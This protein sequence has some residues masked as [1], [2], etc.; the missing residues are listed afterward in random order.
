MVT[1]PLCTGAVVNSFV[2]NCKGLVETPM[3]GVFAVLLIVRR[4]SVVD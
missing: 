4:V 2:F 3:V 1:E